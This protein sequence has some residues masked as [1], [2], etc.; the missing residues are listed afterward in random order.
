MVD[1]VDALAPDDEQPAIAR[2]PTTPHIATVRAVH[3]NRCV[4]GG[5]VRRWAGLINWSP[6]RF[7]AAPRTSSE[8]LP[9]VG[10]R[11]QE[12]TLPAPAVSEKSPGRTH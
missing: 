1:V 2:P 12:V 8:I 10:A 6:R 5:S 9:R 3:R 7:A 4:D 11:Q